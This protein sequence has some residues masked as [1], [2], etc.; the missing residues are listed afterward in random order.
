MLSLKEK[1]EEFLKSRRIFEAEILKF[2]GLNGQDAYN[3]SVPFANKG[4]TLIAGRIEDRTGNASHVRLF[5]KQGEA[6][7]LKPDVSFGLE[8]PFVT[9]IDDQLI[10]GGVRV[11]WKDGQIVSWV[12]DFYKGK[13]VESLTHF[14]TGPS[15]MKDIRLVQLKDGRVGVFSRPQ[16]QEM[17]DKHGCI[18][19][20]GFTIINK[21]EDLTAEVIYNAPFLQNTFLPDEWGGANQALA[22][23]NGLVGVIGHRS[24]RDYADGEERLHYYGIAFTVDPVT[25]EASDN[26]IIISRDCFEGGE[27]KTPR[28]ADVTFTSG[29]VP[30]HNNRA[31][32]YTGLSDCSVGRA[33]IPNPFALS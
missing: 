2:D 4:E 15:H 25:N 32:I 28:L 7:K 21:L 29:I 12:T 17:L 14:A 20:I 9:F 27:H 33:I 23:D 1:Y 18:A 3:P 16:G 10:F 24:Y 30:L 8:D 31:E 22:L 19:K 5:A 13:D 11:I 26:K 6:W